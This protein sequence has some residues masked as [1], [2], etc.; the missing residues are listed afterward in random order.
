MSKVVIKCSTV[1]G[2]HRTNVSSCEE[3]TLL[4]L[5]DDTIP[6]I[7]PDCMKVVFPATVPSAIMDNV[8]WPKNPAHKRYHDQYVRDCLGKK[9]GNVPANL[10]RFLRRCLRYCPNIVNITWYVSCLVIIVIGWNRE[11]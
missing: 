7:D 9:V 8:T 6:H 3:V 1:T 2:I 10:G 4:V 11:E 5:K